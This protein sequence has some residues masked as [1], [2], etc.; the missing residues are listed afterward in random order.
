MPGAEVWGVGIFFWQLLNHSLCS[1][2]IAQIEQEG[3]P[4]KCFVLLGAETA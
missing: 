3:I 2:L 1:A 4:V